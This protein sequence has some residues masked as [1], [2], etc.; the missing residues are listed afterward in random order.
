MSIL[1][2]RETSAGSAGARRATRCAWI[3]SRTFTRRQLMATRSASSSGRTS[4]WRYSAGA[5]LFGSPR[6]SRL[7]QRRQLGRAKAKPVPKPISGHG[8]N[9]LALASEEGWWGD[10]PLAIPPAAIRERPNPSPSFSGQRGQLRASLH[11]G[12]RSRRQ[13][14]RRSSPETARVSS[15]NAS[16]YFL[17]P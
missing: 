9:W 3:G 5:D 7:H 12:D 1:I 2:E 11:A 14:E 17:C 8:G 4:P 13:S 10:I 16:A 6:A 15:S